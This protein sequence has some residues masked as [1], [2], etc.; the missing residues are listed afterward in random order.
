[1]KS[2]T[3]TYLFK[4]CWSSKE[5][6]IEH[7]SQLYNKIVL[8]RIEAISIFVLFSE[9]LPK[10]HILYHFTIF[11]YFNILTENVLVARMG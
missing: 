2:E 10:L 1:M 11:E 9:L 6:P 4:T 5:E 8:Y 3:L 7:F